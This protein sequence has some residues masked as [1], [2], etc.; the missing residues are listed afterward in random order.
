[1]SQ[2]IVTVGTLVRVSIVSEGRRL[3]VGVPA[4][5]PLIELMPGF[6]RSLGVLDPTLAHGGYALHR[7]DATV[8]DPSRSLG[9]QGVHD[10]ELVT[11]VRGGLIAEPRIY[12]DV[13]EAVIDA[14]S[15]QHSDWT[16]RDSARTALAVSLS[17]LALCAVLLLSSGEN[18]GIGAI[19]AGSGVVLLIAT[20]AVLTRIGQP[21][22]GHALGLAAATFGAIA[23]FLAVPSDQIW[24]WPLAAAGLGALVVGGMALAFTHHGPEIHLIPITFG[25]VIGITATIAAVV[26]PTSPAPYAIMVAVIATLANGLPWLALSSTRIRV[27]SPQ[28]DIEVFAPPVPIDAEDVRRRTLAGQRTLVSLRIALGLATLL[29]TP[30]IA[31]SGVTGALLCALAFAGMMF[32]SRQAYARLGVLVVMVLGAVGLTATGLVV[33]GT[34]PQLRAVL[35]TIL[36][37]ATA[38]LVG[39]TLLSPRARLR[40]ARLA[41]TVEVLLLALLLPLGVATAGLL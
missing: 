6:A 24:G 3:D 27:I 22:A 28:S 15:G 16:P 14:T 37:I 39:L 30:L 21:E 36:L 1:M 23:G 11:L 35:L 40:L 32:Q 29:A 38:L 18:F 4:Q 10:G 13:V 8:L 34:Q 33:S 12:D 17:F 25:L 31:S 2:A 19:I 7:A 9:S 5:V 20:A 41:D 26:G